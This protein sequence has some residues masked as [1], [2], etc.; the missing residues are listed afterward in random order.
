ME[1]VHD[2]EKDLL[3]TMARLSLIKDEKAN[4]SREEQLL[5]KPIVDDLSCVGNVYDMFM[6]YFSEKKPTLIRKMFIFV[7]LYFFSPSA[8]AGSKMRRGLREKIAA[9]LGCTSSNISHDYKNV[10]FFYITYKH[11]RNNVNGVI[12]HL[13]E[14]IRKQ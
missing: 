6:D 13:S 8:L 10:S 4:L 11:F 12:A 5:S 1:K 9:V 3:E 2:I 14:N 7:V